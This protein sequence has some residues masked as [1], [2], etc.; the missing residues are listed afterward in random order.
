MTH[1][2]GDYGDNDLDQVLPLNMI[3]MAVDIWSRDLTAK[4]PAVLIT[5]EDLS[6]KQSADDLGTALTHLLSEIKFEQAVEDAVQSALFQMG[7]IKVGLTAPENNDMRGIWAD[8]GRPYAE[9]VLF[10]DF[11]F[12][13][14][15]KRQEEWTFCGNRYT[16]NL[17]DLKENPIYSNTEN[18]QSASKSE[19]SVLDSN[20]RLEDIS[21]NQGG[22]GK[23]EYVDIIELWDIWLPRERLLVT[24]P[25]NSETEKPIR[26]L[27]WQ[28]P[29]GG[30]YFVLGFGKVPGQTVPAGM[31]AHIWDNHV[32]LNDLLVK[33]NAQGLRQKNIGFSPPQSS[34]DGTTKAMIDAADGDVISTVG[35]LPP[36][37][38]RMGGPDQVNMSLAIWIKGLISYA[39]GNLDVLAGL[40]QQ[41]DTATQEKLMAGAS[42]EMMAK[43][44]G[45]TETFVTDVIEALALHLWTDP[46][47]KL[48]LSRQVGEFNI[49]YEWGPE[50]RESNFFE[51]N[52]KIHPHSMR[53][54]SPAQKLAML[55]E[56]VQN[57]ILPAAQAGM[58]QSQGHDFDIKAYLKIK[59]TYGDMPELN[60]ILISSTGPLLSGPNL[61]PERIP[62]PANTTRT[63]IRQNVPTGGTQQSQDAIMMQGFMSGGGSVNPDQ[64]A[65]LAR[66]TVG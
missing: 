49:P 46:F 4:N 31:V 58:L 3:R 1:Y 17:A 39:A 15:A 56:T 11:V 18:L 2:A 51:Y 14:N 59:A 29:E 16:A 47:V 38:L 44:Q 21:R 32:V 26:V 8:G 5:T 37:E 43:L 20:E 40:S 30:P 33:I 22:L 57:F 13:M 27:D 19:N 61:N 36:N 45:T 53:S 42:S 6:L 55:D 25:A 65:S 34:H 10:S 60:D 64:A 50:D 63:N 23:E 54:K 12:D 7:I 41:A 52:F 28:G 48:P 62:A 24:M 66:P 35:G 9:S